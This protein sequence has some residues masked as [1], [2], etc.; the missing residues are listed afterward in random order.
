MGLPSAEEMEVFEGFFRSLGAGWEIKISG[1]EPF[2]YPGFLGVVEGLVET[3]LKISVVTN[4]SF[5]RAVYRRFFR[6]CGDQLRSFSVSLHRE[7][8]DWRDFLKKCR[9]AKKKINKTAKGSLVVNSVVEPGR[10]AE[11]LDIKRAYEE[12]GIRFYPQLMRKKGKA[13]EYAPRE[14]EVIRELA[15]DRDPFKINAGYNLKGGTCYAGLH[16]FIVTPEGKCFTC[17]PGKR[18]GS[19]YMGSITEGD[20]AFRTQPL[21]CPYDLCPCTVPI[22]RKIAPRQAAGP[23]K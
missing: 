11:L 16:Y 14:Q 1:G 23:S 12:R 9:W 18:D 2:L 17:Y 3:G 20:F 10:A 21:Q 19:G 5:P 8:V 6:S 13:V 15:G 7:K 22:N 4:F